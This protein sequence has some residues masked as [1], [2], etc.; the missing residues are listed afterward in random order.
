MAAQ[1]ALCLSVVGEAD[2]CW[3]E[4][5][6]SISCHNVD[7]CLLHSRLLLDPRRPSPSHMPSPRYGFF[8][9][10]FPTFVRRICSDELTDLPMKAAA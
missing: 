6:T 1:C 9:L 3:I 8:I 2:F 7:D 10:Y 4:S 5:W